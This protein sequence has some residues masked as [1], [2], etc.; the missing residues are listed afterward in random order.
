MSLRFGGWDVI[1]DEDLPSAELGASQ[2]PGNR[3]IYTMYHGTTVASARLII[4]NGFRQ[5]E[6]GMLGKG[7]YVSRDPTKAQRYPLNHPDTDRVVLELRVRVGRVKRIDRDNHQLQTSWSQQGYDTAWVPPNCG[8]RAVPSGLEEDC[9]F[10]PKNIRV[11]AVAKAPADVL[12]ELQ[13]LV[14]SHPQN[15]RAGG[16]AGPVCRLCMRDV[17]LGSHV[18][19]AC[20]S[21]NQEICPFMPQH[22]CSGRF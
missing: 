15:P 9:V 8:M 10:D 19:Q 13:Q 6:R 3:R 21:C 17:V 22:E 7:V 11:V 4:A 5:S 1:Y 20:W 16:G 14:A 12:P 2:P 18:T